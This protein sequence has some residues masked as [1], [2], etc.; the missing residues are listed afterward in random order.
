MKFFITESCLANGGEHAEAGTIIEVSRTEAQALGM[1]G[2]GYPLAA[3][4][5]GAASPE[6]APAPAPEPAKPAD[7]AKPGK[8]AK[9]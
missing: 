6:P 9:P 3:A 8:P 1:A 4:L 2:R 5:P 7:E